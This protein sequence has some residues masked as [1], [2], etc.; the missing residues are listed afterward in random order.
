MQSTG[1]SVG[2]GKAV[3]FSIIPALVFFVLAETGLRM[4]VAYKAEKE[5]GKALPAPAQRN[6][7]QRLDPVLGYG[8][9]PGYDKSGIRVNSLGFRGPE[10]AA[11][12]P[13]GT[14]RIVALGDST[15]FG[16]AGED[17][18]YPAQL[19]RIITEM[20]PLRSVEVI[21]AGVEG[22]STIYAARLLEHRVMPL[23]PDVVLIYV[24][25]ND[26]YGIS[27]FVPNHAPLH[28][29]LL[30]EPNEPDEH[31]LKARIAKLLDHIYLAQFIRRIIYLELPRLA[32]RFEK[33]IDTKAGRQPHPAA[34]DLYKARLKHLVALSREGGA[35]PVLMTLPTVLSPQMSER[36]LSVI[37][38]PSWS[39]GDYRLLYRVV[40]QMNDAIRGVA[41]EAQVAVIDNA[42]FFDSL[43]N[44]GRLFFDTLHMY[45]EGYGLLAQNIYRELARQGIVPVHETSSD[46]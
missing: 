2:R 25:W 24:G 37:H 33:R 29:V 18:P 1:R 40:Q 31:S 15:T 21:N 11:S 27:P 46:K 26:L 7:Y 10:V 42:R 22:Y 9:L 30:P 4:Y 28:E 17:C 32:A 38:Y 19:Q 44:K 16:L 8:L 41:E 5:A 23:H 6:E 34:F 20:L 14:L 43:D 12:K 39:Q 36:D 13:P 3:I 35:K 45:C